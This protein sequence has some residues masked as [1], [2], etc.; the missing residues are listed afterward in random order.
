ML[1][2]TRPLVAWCHFAIGSLTIADAAAI[3][4]LAAHEHS[5]AKVAL[6]APLGICCV[7]GALSYFWKQLNLL[8]LYL[9]F[10]VT[11][12]W[13]VALALQK[14]SGNASVDSLSL[15]AL[16]SLAGISVL[17]IVGTHKSRRKNPPEPFTFWWR[18]SPLFLE[19]I[20]PQR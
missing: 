11:S 6:L 15:L 7:I 8:A 16:L 12:V 14:L 2:T 18:M 20:W 9:L 17:Y 10:S 3:G 19:T 5:W 4:R 1:N 13:F